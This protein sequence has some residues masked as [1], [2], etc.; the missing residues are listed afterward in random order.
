[1]SDQSR[2]VLCALLAGVALLAGG[3][4]GYSYNTQSV[5]WLRDAMLVNGTGQ[6]VTL[7]IALSLGV[8]GFSEIMSW[9]AGSHARRWSEPLQRAREALRSGPPPMHGDVPPVLQARLREQLKEIEAR[10]EHHFRVFTDFYRWHFIAIGTF[11]LSALAAAVALF[12]ITQDGW[13]NARNGKLVTVFVVTTASAVLYRSFI[14]VYRQAE[15]TADNKQLYKN[16]V[17]LGNEVRSFCALGGYRVGDELKT[18]ADFIDHVDHKLAEFNNVSVG[19]DAT[20][21]PTYEGLLEGMRKSPGVASPPPAQGGG[22][23]PHGG[24]PGG[25]EAEKGER[26]WD[27]RRPELGG[28]HVVQPGDKLWHISELSYGDGNRWDVI[29]NAN[30]D[31]VKNKDY[32]QAGWRLWIPPAAAAR[33]GR[34]GEGGRPPKEE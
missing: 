24:D 13:A 10:A 25:R 26:V 15:N 2:R 9:M 8:F 27:P 21:V 17:A 32:I 30:S 12:F 34:N 18:A 29:V 14:G 31:L 7:T 16:Y 11:S 4:I 19:F 5:T 28:Y 33:L 23:P 20:K 6:I 1:M 22:E 3:A